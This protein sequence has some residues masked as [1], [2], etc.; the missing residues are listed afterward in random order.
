MTLDRR[1]RRDEHGVIAVVTA[2]AATV[3]L[4]A[5]ALAIDLGNTWARRGNLQ[6][7]ADQAA[8]FAA[9]YLPADD[10]PSR[11]KVAKAAA[12]YIVCHP[13]PGQREIDSSIP[14]TCPS[15]ADDSSL[16]TYADQLLS[17]GNVTF[18]TIDNGSGTYVQVTT[19]PARIDFGFGV[20]AGKK[21]STQVKTATA[22]VG[23]PGSVSPMSLSL[24]CLLSAAINLP[25]GLG[26]SLSGILPLNYIAP[27]PITVDNVVTKWPSGM[28][29][30]STI[31]IASL[32]PGSATQNIDP[33]PGVMTGAGLTLLQPMRLVFALGD[34]SGASVGSLPYSDITGVNLVA[35]TGAFTVPA[36]VYDKVG[37][38]QVKL[39]VQQLDGSWQYSQQDYAYP[40]NIPSVTADLLGCA[41]LIKTPRDLQV[42]TP[43]NLDYSLKAG[44]DHPLDFNPNMLTINT[45]S[46]TNVQSMLTAI[47][48][49][50]SLTSCNNTLPNIYD[51]G[52]VHPTA[53]CV[54]PE[55]GANTY[56][57]FTDG[58]LGPVETVPAD[59][60]THQAA[61]Q[62]AGRLVCTD[63]NPCKHSFT[64]PGFPGEQINDDQFMDFVKPDRQNTLTESMFF[65]LSTYLTPGIPAVTPDSALTSDLYDSARFMWVP[66][67]SSPV[68]P[69]S[70]N[71]YPILT[72]RPI[73]ITQYAPIGIDSV[74]MV[75]DL[76][77]TWV[78]SLLGIDP[79]NDHGL[80]M[81]ADGT[82]LRAL[83][84]M[85]I[86]PS[87]LPAVPEN[88]D[89][90]ITDYVGTGPKVVR[91]VR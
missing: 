40:V 69:N 12:Y 90:V 26:S 74:D 25:G 70:A 16:D 37:T 91:L 50:T 81:S 2:I 24:N 85:T 56:K 86:E 66:V 52:G 31:G 1:S 21:S 80:L 59:N 6:G 47:E 27:G 7:Q 53:N 34:Q 84:F 33:G 68:A 71:Y 22:H 75:A 29:K 36:A 51:N 5:G 39:A 20:M 41:R 11:K 42:G 64:L 61:Y 28:S 13:V 78:K 62:A 54:M 3:M 9:H 38:W 46:V 55:Q 32:T 18:P 43:G 17:S 44:I 49:V 60:S 63:T 35:L 19:P 8:L 79:A 14:S 57:E 89:G 48:D 67:I 82:T 15:S 65:N 30:T 58:M 83:R 4:V 23:S 10:A 76:V 73:F 88:Y 45:S 77:D 87:A 72:W